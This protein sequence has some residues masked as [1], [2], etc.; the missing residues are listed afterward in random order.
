[1]FLA[2]ATL[3]R[4]EADGRPP[5]DLP[6]VRWSMSYAFSEIQA[7]FEQI[8][9]NLEIPGLT[10]LM[11]GPLGL[12]S[13]MNPISSRPDDRTG[14][15]VAVIL[16]TPGPQRDR[17]TDGIHLPDEKDWPVSRLDHAMELSV[18]AEPIVSLVKNAAR[19]R[20]IQRGALEDML[21]EA[22]EKR[23]ISPEDARQVQDAEDVRNDTIQVDSFTLEE[24]G[25]NAVIPDR[26]PAWRDDEV[27]AESSAVQRSS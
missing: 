22:V 17:L 19:S 24:Y 11:R 10:W 3:R 25:L 14:H 8:Y 6:L 4:F 27:T 7:S 5:E 2:V 13:R 23:L 12:F 16:Q 21:S 1:M 9:A 26:E 18:A 20:T 15:Q